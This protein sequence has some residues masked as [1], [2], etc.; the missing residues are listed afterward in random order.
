MLPATAFKMKGNRMEWHPV[1][2]HFPLV[3][4]P[5]SVCLDLAAWWRRRP[6]WHLLAYTLLLVGT[7]AALAAV[8][9]GTEAASRWA[10]AAVREQID[11]HE[12]L[13][14]IALFVFVGIVLGRLPLHL[15]GRHQDWR[16]KGLIVA[17]ALACGILWQA[18]FYGGELVYKYGVGVRSGEQFRGAGEGGALP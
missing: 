13:A 11:R 10:H 2:V 14:T 1:A 4:L 7:L 9:T 15:L 16:L 12:D 17:A 6:E 8:L 3:L 5:L 18:A